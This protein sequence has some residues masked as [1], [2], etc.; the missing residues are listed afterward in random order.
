MGHAIT[1][2][3]RAVAAR[4]RDEGSELSHA[5]DAAIAGDVRGVHRARV[6][7]RRLSEALPVAGAILGKDLDAHRRQVRRLRR[8]L[9]DAAP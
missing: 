2:V 1:G 9:R 5:L 3:Q 4:L 7:S 8:A 6:A